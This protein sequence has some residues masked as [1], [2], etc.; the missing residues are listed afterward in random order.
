[1]AYPTGRRLATVSRT[2]AL[3]VVAGCYLAAGVAALLA[4][5]LLSGSHPIAITLAA[6]LVA[7]GVVFAGSMLLANSSLY[8]PY[9]SVVPPVVA[10][11][12]AAVASGGPPVRRAVVIVL[13]AAWGVRL[14]GNWV[15]S[16]SGL[17]HEDWRYVQLREQTAGRLPWWLVSLGGIQLMPTLVVFAGM[18][19]LWPA[20]TGSRPV[21]LLDL[22]ALAVTAGAITVETVADLQL[23]RFTGDV[24]NR[25][26]VADRGLWAYC[27]HPNYLGEIGFWWGLWLFGL[28]GDP[29][30]WWTVA[31]PLIILL[32]FTTA[33]IPL[34]DR[35]LLQRRPGY[36]DYR[37]R[38][39]LIPWPRP[40]RR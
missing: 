33:S 11:A 17:G 10:G 19:S 22:A 5:R 31:G 12:W 36:A 40:G 13:V 32:L 23:H 4:V 16:W 6:D 20:L 29:S 28:A 8:D 9:W 3:A 26:K 15:R 35:R 27:R 30:W 38:V 1:M 24:A 7:T 21:G 14:T 18:L 37:R 39:P 25:G 34:M 2:G